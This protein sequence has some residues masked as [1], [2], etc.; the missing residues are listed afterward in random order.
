MV[1]YSPSINGLFGV[2]QASL[3][4]QSLRYAKKIIL[5]ISDICLWLF[6]SQALILNKNPYLWMDNK[7]SRKNKFTFLALRF[8]LG[9]VYFKEQKAL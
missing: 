7:G 1:N 8:R 3:P 5:G 2:S 6:F 4:A 9:L